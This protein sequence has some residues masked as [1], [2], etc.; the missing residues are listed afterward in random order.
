MTL[1]ASGAISLAD[2][3][4]EFGDATGSVSFE[5]YYKGTKNEVPP[6]FG[7]GNNPNI[8]TSGSGTSISLNDFYSAQNIWQTTI[9]S[10]GARSDKF[11][12]Y[13][14]YETGV[15]AFGEIGINGNFLYNLTGKLKRASISRFGGFL[16]RTINI[17]VSANTSINANAWT[18]VTFSGATST[19]RIAKTSMAY[20]ATDTYFNFGIVVS[21]SSGAGEPKPFAPVGSKMTIL[22]ENNG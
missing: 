12:A 18:T 19:V 16:A 13:N 17:T 11:S 20:S 8:P 9:T 3:R 14:G 7:A 21:I 4:D 22:F 10:T 15:L 2:L 5:R 6:S 1:P